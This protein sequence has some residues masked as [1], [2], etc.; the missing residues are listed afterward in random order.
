MQIEK[1]CVPFPSE[2]GQGDATNIYWIGDGRIIIDAGFD[3][4]SN[5][6]FIKRTLREKGL[7]NTKIL[8]THGHLDHFGLSSF[9][10]EQTGA[11]ILIHE[12]DA[13][14]MRD[15]NRAMDW[16]D[17]VYDLALEGGF[18][19]NELITTKIELLAAVDLMKRPRD[20]KTFMDL[21][22]DVGGSKLHS[23]HLP[24]HTPGSVGYVLGDAVLSGD[25]AIEG[26]TVLGDLRKEIDSIQKLKVFREIFTGHRRTP[27]SIGDL[28]A[29][30]AHIATR[31]SEVL[32]VT[33]GGKNLKGIVSVMYPWAS[34]SDVNFVRKLIPL[35]QVIS[36][37][38]YL[39]D[40]GGIVKRGKLWFSLK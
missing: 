22:L 10:Q 29:L 23:I 28:E 7:K 40:E 33:K 37:I 18:T 4:P 39:E 30:E 15:Y 35:R 27:I 12:A 11:E 6:D 1:L 25:V 9:I 36:Y 3:S 26:S 13:E 31:L 16:F 14:V 38:R 34:G 17:E 5:R 8:I 32:A 2:W 21:E 24:G 20:F 19:R